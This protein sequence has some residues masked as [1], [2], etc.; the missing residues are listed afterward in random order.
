MEADRISNLPLDLTYNILECLPLQEA[1]KTSVLSQHWRFLWASIPQLVLDESFCATIVNGKSEPADI[2]LRYS[3]VVNSI[4]LSHVGPISKFVLFVPSFPGE[5]YPWVNYVFR[6][7]E[8]YPNLKKKLP[9]CLFTCSGLTHL[10]L[11]GCKLRSLPP[12]FMG[13]P[14]LIYF[15]LVGSQELSVETKKSDYFGKIPI[16]MGQLRTLNLSDIKL[17]KKSNISVLF[18]LFASSPQLERLYIEISELVKVTDDHPLQIDCSFTLRC[19]RKVQLLRV[20]GWIRELQLIKYILAHSPVLGN[21]TNELHKNME[22]EQKYN[23][24]LEAMRYCR[25]SPN[26]EI[27][28][29]DK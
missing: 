11:I 8:F 20:S 25:A 28:I 16:K 14:C 19:L 3:K 27:I 17:Y 13:F 23:F 24:A 7:G 22:V 5:R 15:K 29:K 9:E 12:S 10:T 18:C 1:A 26:A 4:L 2:S 6:D 21:M